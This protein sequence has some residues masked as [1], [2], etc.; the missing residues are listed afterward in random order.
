MF[1]STLFTHANSEGVN[2][3][4]SAKEKIINQMRERVKVTRPV[5]ERARA[6]R[7]NLKKQFSVS[8]VI[9]SPR[10][11]YEQIL[12]KQARGLRTLRTAFQL[13]FGR[14]NYSGNKTISARSRN[15]CG[16]ATKPTE[17]TFANSALVKELFGLFLAP[18]PSV[19]S[20]VINGRSK[21]LTFALYL[22]QRA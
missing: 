8:R 2:P 16:T 13:N 11:R 14:S 19:L 22:G 3:F 6:D 7:S 4:R 5:A 10:R 21:A 12:I 17:A 20:M 9:H 1:F 18:L 15:Q